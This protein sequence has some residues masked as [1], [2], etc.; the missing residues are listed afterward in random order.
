[1]CGVWIFG[2]GGGVWFWFLGMGLGG[3]S[4]IGGFSVVFYRVLGWFYFF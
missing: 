4:G 2:G 1:M 3:V